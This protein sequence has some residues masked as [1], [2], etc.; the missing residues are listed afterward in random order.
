MYAAILYS[1]LPLFSD[2]CVLYASPLKRTHK[3]VSC[4]LLKRTGL[5][6]HAR[7]YP[8]CVLSQANI[9]Q[10]SGNCSVFIYMCT[11]FSVFICVACS[12]YPRYLTHT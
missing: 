1:E 7:G 12:L 8:A 4:L 10:S 11:C 3:Q 2:D 9:E 6:T 5:F